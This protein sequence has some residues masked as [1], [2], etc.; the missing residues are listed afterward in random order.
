MSRLRTSSR[1]RVAAGNALVSPGSVVAPHRVLRLLL[2]LGA[3]LQF[4]ACST[5]YGTAVRQFRE[6]PAC[7]TS[8]AELPLQSIR[9]GD[10][11]SF[12]L[13]EGAPAFRFETGKS[14]FRAFALPQGPYPY[15]VTVSSFLMGNRLKSAYLFSPQ[16]I[17]ID[18]RRRVVRTP[19]P[20]SFTLGRAG[21]IET[22]Q[23]TG[24]LGY[25]LEGGLTFTADNR[26][27]RYLVVLTTDELLQGKTPVSTAGSVPMFLPAYG[28][29]APSPANEAEVPHAPMGK[30]AV[31]VAPIVSEKPVDVA[32]QASLGGEGKAPA[33]APRPTAVT[34]RLASGKVVGELELGRTT[35][36]EARRLFDTACAGMGPER[37]SGATVTIG[38]TILAPKRFYVPPGTHHQLYFDEKGILV[39]FVAGKSGD[40]PGNGTE[41]LQRFPGAR[42]T[43]RTLNSR[44]LQASIAPCVTL[45]A[46]F[47]SGDD[48]LDSAA[49]AYS[50]PTK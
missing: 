42:E 47:S 19:G 37:R 3:A 20:G 11:E 10:K 34:V 35:V 50:C 27:E 46:L 22:V 29:T 39:L 23:E 9:M 45:I 16:L 41:F 21:L 33:P 12:E 48:T 26:D 44:E 4:Q 43:G 18:E 32:A 36:E 5:S 30:V 25:K 31:S 8:L 17:T 13:G 2:V 14:Y 15:R 24:G 1:R 28:R 7:C 40:L 38:T 49:H 6:V